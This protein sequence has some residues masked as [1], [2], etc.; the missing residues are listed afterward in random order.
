M[1]GQMV[2]RLTPCSGANLDASFSSNTLDTGYAQKGDLLAVMYSTSDQE[3]SSSTCPS[4]SNGLVA[5]AAAE[6]VRTTRFTVPA[7]THDLMT[8]RVPWTAAGPCW[9]KTGPYLFLV[10]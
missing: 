2:T 7:L 10:V 6:E 8:F 3:S 1:T 4:P 5:T 9:Q